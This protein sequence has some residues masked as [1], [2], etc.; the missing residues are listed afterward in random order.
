MVWVCLAVLSGMVAAPSSS[1]WAQAAKPKNTDAPAGAAADARAADRA[2]IAAMHD[3]FVKAFE[4]RDAAALAGHWT[5]EGEYEN[6]AGV[7]V[8]GRDA[9]AKGFAFFFAKTPEVKAE[10]K[11]AALRF[12]GRDTAAGQGTVTVRRGPAEPATRAR[13][14]ALIVREEGRWRLAKLSESPADEPSL[15]DLAWLIGQWKT[16]RGE[17]AEILTTYTWAPNKKFIH[18][19]FTLKEKTLSLSGK[20]VIGVD[21]A[22][23]RIRSW[24]FEAD[25]GVGVGDWSRDGDHWTIEASGTLVD[26]RSLTETNVLRRVND[27]TLTWQSVNRLLDDE[28]FA[29]LPPV[30]VTRV[31]AVK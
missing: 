4:A 22:T 17:G 11:P 9:L 30:K 7:T 25:G 24:T 2:A 1:V 6:E 14:D 31:K 8:Q 19:D 26:G 18:V 21:P 28:E 27:D 16:S 12:L 13:F 10:M 5:T 29:D 15:D 23:G 3:S 20:Q